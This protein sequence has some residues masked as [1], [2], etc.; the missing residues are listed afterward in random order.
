MMQVLK[1]TVREEETVTERGF[2][3]YL[4]SAWANSHSRMF[5]TGGTHHKFCL[6]LKYWYKELQTKAGTW[7][8]KRIMTSG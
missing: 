5:C 2:F 7:N 6:K 4:S 3:S 8:V 1:R